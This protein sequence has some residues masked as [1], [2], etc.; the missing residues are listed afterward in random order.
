MPLD[1]D[2][3]SIARPQQQETLLQLR[4]RVGVRYWGCW[5]Q[6]GVHA[7]LMNLWSR[8][9]MRS[10][11]PG[12]GIGCRALPVPLPA[13]LC[14]PP[15]HV[16]SEFRTGTIDSR[17]LHPPHGR[18]L[19]IR[20]FQWYHL[21]QHPVLEAYHGIQVN[22][23]VVVYVTILIPIDPPPLVTRRSAG[24]L[25]HEAAPADYGGDAPLAQR[26]ALMSRHPLHLSLDTDPTGAAS[27]Q[28]LAQSYRAP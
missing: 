25:A 17:V 24:E 8:H 19:M 21:D 10:S 4:V 3:P 27:I 2:V 16:H 13:R 28:S 11:H 1:K 14:F 9:A 15:A 12:G 26:G 22:V 6:H 20:H 23:A 5:G 7:Q 18:G